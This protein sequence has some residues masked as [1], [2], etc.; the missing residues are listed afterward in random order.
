MDTNSEMIPTKERLA[1]AVIP[2]SRVSTR[3]C[4]M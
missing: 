4:L 3:V 1:N 2:T